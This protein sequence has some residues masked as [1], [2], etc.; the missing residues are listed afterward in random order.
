MLQLP[1]VLERCAR[2]CGFAVV[3]VEIQRR[4]SG[5]SHVLYVH[6]WWIWRRGEQEVSAGR[7]G[8]DGGWGGM[9]M[10]GGKEGGGGEGVGLDGGAEGCG[11]V[12]GVGAGGEEEHAR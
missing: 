12:E 10:Q 5:S 3:R 4:G 9:E 6:G 8:E 2:D 11:E 1:V 7:D